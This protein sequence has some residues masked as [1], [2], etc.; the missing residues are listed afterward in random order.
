LVAARRAVSSPF[1]VCRRL[2]QG[3]LHS[4]LKG[5]RRLL[6]FG[7]CQLQ[8]VQVNISEYN[9]I[10]ILEGGQAEAH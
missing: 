8:S 9:Q 6:Q 3:G 4:P 7:P 2:G 5:P 1:F 10:K